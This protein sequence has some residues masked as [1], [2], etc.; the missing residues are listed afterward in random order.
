MHVALIH[1]ASPP[2]IGGVETVLARQAQSLAHAGHQV[3]VITGRGQTWNSDIPVVQLPLIDSRH[4][5]ILTMKKTLDQGQ[6]PDSFRGM[7]STIKEQLRGALTGVDVLIAHNV[8]SLNKN[9][10]LT[11]ALYD[12]SQEPEMPHFILWHHDLAWTTPRYQ[13]ELHP[14]WPWDLLCTAWPGVRQV[15]VSDARR[16]ELAQLM[17]IPASAITVVPA[18]IDL[19]EFFKL[20]R[21]TQALVAKYQLT[22]ANPLLLTPVRLTPRKNLE[23]AIQVMKPLVNLD[24]NAVLVITGPPGAH[25]PAN[26]DYFRQLKELCDSLNLRKSVIFLADDEPNGVEDSTIADLYRLADALLLPSREEGF[27][28]PILEAGL[29]HLPIFCTNLPPLQALAGDFATYFSPDGSP[30]EVA[31]AIFQHISS[32]AQSQ[33]KIR[34]R[35]RY[36]WESIYNQQIAPLLEFP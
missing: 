21:Q 12:L 27:G 26:T 36:T 9:L 31:Q 18:G 29:S 6:L 4:D 35:T 25:N 23:F 16:D 30:S 22:Q 2:I 24:P 33:M 11:T 3:R 13:P 8:A 1:Y 32:D 17:R 5:E 10:A 34:V 7:V 14:G 28:I 19:A 20:G 15:V